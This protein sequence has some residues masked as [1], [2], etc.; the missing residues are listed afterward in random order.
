MWPWPNP[1]SRSRGFWIFRKLHFSKSI[2]SAFPLHTSKLMVDYGSMWAGLQPVRARFLNFS[3]SWRS[4]DFEAH[5]MLILPEPLGLVSTLHEA[6]SLWLWMQVERNKPH[7]LAW[8][9]IE[10]KVGSEL[11][12]VAIYESKLWKFS[13]QM[14][15][16]VCCRTCW[17]MK[18]SDLKNSL[19]LISGNL[20]QRYSMQNNVTACSKHSQTVSLLSQLFHWA[21]LHVT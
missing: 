18:I 14:G 11:G 13:H 17:A 15:N 6:R 12:K 19:L 20:I 5:E 3:R 16:K 2:S 21:K 9:K 10:V 7:T 8:P 4:R 1:R